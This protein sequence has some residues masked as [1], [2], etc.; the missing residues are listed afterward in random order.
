MFHTTIGKLK[1]KSCIWNASGV[2]CR[3][4]E[5]LHNLDAC[6]D[7]AVVLSKSCT[8]NYRDGNPLPRYFE[9][10]PMTFSI[11][12]SGLPNMGYLEYDKIATDIKKPYFI[13]VAGLK[14][15]TN[16][17]MISKLSSNPNISG[18][19]LNLS[20]PNIIGKPQ[21]GY[22]FE[23]MDN[24]LKEVKAVIHSP[25]ITF[26]VKMPPYFDISHWET[27]AKILNRY[28]L[29]FITCINSLGNGLVIDTES[30]S[31]VI[32]PKNGF[33]GIGGIGIKPIA[34]SNVNKFYRLTNSSIIGCGGIRN[35]E[36]AFHHILA[37]A[38]AIQ[39][40]TQFKSEGFGCFKRILN[41]LAE[42]MKRKKYGNILDFRGK[43]N[44]I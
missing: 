7:T 23:A 29:D 10:S 36:D 6:P 25:T 11:N 40:G 12:S 34:L 19:E 14:K 33:G 3:T 21:I 43:L 5:D 39:I 30:E 38:S 37:G 1:L 32:K 28:D 8:A 42:I 9:N 24:L 26:G 18:I 20:C 13:S 4:I 17:K 41:E 16:V 44:S 2:N 15:D 31:V 35:G 22:D 27:S